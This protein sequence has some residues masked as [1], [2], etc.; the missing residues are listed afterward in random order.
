MDFLDKIL[1]LRDEK[2]WSEYRLS[3]ESGIPQS[4]ISS[5]FRKKAQPSIQSLQAICNAFGITLSAFFTD[6]NTT[7]VCLTDQQRRLL[8][9]FAHLDNEQ[10]E[11]L[12]HFL[13]KFSFDR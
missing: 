8:D 10:Q 2:G 13:S 9:E 12:I 4:T 3:V 6:S 11:A 5:W 7:T 1:K